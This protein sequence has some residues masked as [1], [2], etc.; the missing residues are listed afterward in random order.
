MQSLQNIHLSELKM[1]SGLGF[2]PSGL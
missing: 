1:S 2:I